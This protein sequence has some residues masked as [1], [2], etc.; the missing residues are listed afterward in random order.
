MPGYALVDGY[1]RAERSQAL[2]RLKQAAAFAGGTIVDFAFYAEEAV[3]VSVELPTGALGRLEQ[4]LEAEDVHLFEHTR[5]VIAAA[6]TRSS[7]P[8]LALLHVALL[9]SA[10]AA[11]DEAPSRPSPPAPVPR[12]LAP[13]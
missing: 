7:R 8:L 9:A 2:A 3:R 5:R 10:D 6:A 4:A 1:T 13:P 11:V 12:T